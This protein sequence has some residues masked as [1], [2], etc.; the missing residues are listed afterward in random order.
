M[1]NMFKGLGI[2]L[3]AMLFMG[4][5]SNVWAQEPVII[6]GNLELSGNA[7]AY[8]T[9]AKEALELLIEQ[10]NQEGGILDG[11][12][13]QSEII[14]N[15]SNLTESASIATRLAQGE[16]VGIIGPT[17]TA[18]SKAAIP[19][20]NEAQIAN[21]FAA[22]TGDGLTL[23]EDGNVL[24]YIF[25]VCFEDSYQGTAAGNFAS[26]DLQS[27]KAII[28]TDQALEYSL[29]LADAFKES[30]LSQGGQI[31][32]EYSY[33]SGDTDFMALLTN[34]LGQD[35]DLLYIPGY[36]TEIGL[37]IKQARELGI[38]QPIMGGDGYHSQ[39]LVELA[40]AHNATDIYFTTHFT[41]E[42]EDPA[43]QE[44]LQA[45]EN[46]YGKT[47]DT[48]A[49]LAYDA[50]AILVDAI[51]RA[52]STDRQAIAQALAETKDFQGVTGTF[53]M[54]EVH[55]PTKSALMLRLDQGQVADIFEAGN[56]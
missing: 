40:G 44:F 21:I 3:I 25:R 38:S 56:E 51:E 9:P 11:R 34:L 52:E 30:Y 27:Q 48:F 2:M 29:A 23:G 31:I 4:S 20:T 26:Q 14:D 43:V 6:G 42:N 5:L 19:I 41:S 33:Q 10:I 37:L 45:F 39:T 22:T 49:A 17:A 7:A 47:A 15:Q 13:L 32:A 12:P 16:A 28:I 35:Y 24:E 1:K 46:K 50:G 53:S 36:Y 18:V 8:G 55:N 54:D